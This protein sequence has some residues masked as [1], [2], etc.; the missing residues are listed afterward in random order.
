[1]VL[2]SRRNRVKLEAMLMNNPDLSVTRA[3]EI[4]SAPSKGELRRWMEMN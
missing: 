1:M 4:L 2:G 3:L